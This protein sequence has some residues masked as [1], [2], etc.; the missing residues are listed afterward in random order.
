MGEQPTLK[1]IDAASRIVYEDMPPTPQYR[2]SMLCERLGA[3]LWVKHENQ[4][5][6]GAF[7][8][9]GGL[10]YFRHLMQSAKPPDGVISATRGNH[11]QS[12]AISR[13]PWSLPSRWPKKNPCTWFRLFTPC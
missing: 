4:T 8:I 12:T 9:R 3:E 2:W 11:G 13:N 7:K 10:V 1:D 5:P 6:V